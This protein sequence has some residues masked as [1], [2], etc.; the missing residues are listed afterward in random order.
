LQQTIS[1]PVRLSVPWPDFYYCR[2]FSVFMLWGALPDERTGLQFTGTIRCQS[3][4]Q[5]PQNS[6]PHL[7][8]SFGTTGFPFCRLLRLAGVR[9]RY[10]KPPPQGDGHTSTK[11]KSK[12]KSHY[13]RQSV[14]QSVMVSGAHLGPATNFSFSSNFLLD[15]Y[16]LLLYSVISDERA[17]L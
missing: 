8:V 2:T 6:W 9:C 3:R 16:C 14:G 11:S 12:W 5:V 15:T 17:G 1:Q 10:S 13:D 7:N 4:V